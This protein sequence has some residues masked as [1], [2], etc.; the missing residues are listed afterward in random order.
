MTK[1]LTNYPDKLLSDNGRISAI[2]ARYQK[3][4][5]SRQLKTLTRTD[6]R[7]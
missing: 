1:N 3:S 2:L 5:C 4:G 7:G 6:I